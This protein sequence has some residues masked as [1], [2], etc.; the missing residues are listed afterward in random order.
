MKHRDNRPVGS[1]LGR[2]QGSWMKGW[3]SKRLGNRFEGWRRIVG[4]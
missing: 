3:S 4:S 1:R 2:S